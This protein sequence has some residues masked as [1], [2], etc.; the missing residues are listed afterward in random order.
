MQ[1]LGKLTPNDLE[2]LLGNDRGYRVSI[3]FPVH[4]IK[5]DTSEDSIRLKN[6]VRRAQAD[7]EAHGL[8][9]PDAEAL[10]RDATSLVDDSAFWRS[11]GNGVALFASV[12]ETRVYRLPLS[13]EELV[14]VGESFHIK[15]LLP[16]LSGNGHYSLLALSKSHLRLLQG[17]RWRIEDVTP[18]KIPTSLQEFLQYDVFEKQSQVHTAGP[19]RGAGASRAA[20]FHGHGA[21][22][23]DDKAR[24]EE[25]FRHV[26]SGVS[27]RLRRHR[28]PLVLAGVD[29]LRGLYRTVNTYSYLLED[30]ISG[31][32][33]GLAPP[34]LHAKATEILERHYDR[35]KDE[36]AG[37]VSDHL[38]TGLVALDLR[39]V[40]SAAHFGRVDT[41]FVA[42]DRQEWGRFDPTSGDIERSSEPKPGSEDLLDRATTDT[43]MRRG[44]VFAVESDR[45]PG[46]T[47]AAALLRY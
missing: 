22:E 38:G 35:A 17:D 3:Y 14:V 24:I 42:I 31:S 46:D 29:H 9:R 4:P 37:R 19:A 8:R 47:S 21:T 6:L 12:G 10:L 28:G 11:G 45:V 25:Y 20:Q 15:P 1:R 7:L 23:R 33:D 18:T 16:L 44:R 43:L 39:D 40:L 27:E 36:A 41:L 13:F 32:P 5:R 30:G 34:E 2:T 26:D